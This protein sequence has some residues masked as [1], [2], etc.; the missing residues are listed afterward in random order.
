MDLLQGVQQQGGERAASR[1][2][3]DVGDAFVSGLG[4]NLDADFTD[5]RRFSYFMRTKK[6]IVAAI[7]GPAAGIGSGDR[8]LCR[9]AFR[10]RQGG[11]DDVTSHNAV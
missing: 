8:A 6:P 3:G 7:N 11:A 9:Y 2:A 4:P 1:G 10:E 5:M